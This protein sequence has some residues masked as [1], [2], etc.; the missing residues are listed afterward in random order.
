MGKVG[1][2][3]RLFSFSKELHFEIWIPKRKQLLGANGADV[4]FQWVTCELFYLGFLFPKM[5]PHVLDEGYLY[6]GLHW[7]CQCGTHTGFVGLLNWICSGFSTR[8]PHWL[9]MWGWSW[10]LPFKILIF[11]LFILLLRCKNAIFFSFFLIM[12]YIWLYFTQ[13]IILFVVWFKVKHRTGKM[14]L[15]Y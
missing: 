5:G 11:N 12:K 1:Q 4:G 13:T 15:L 2:K 6:V 8:A 3:W 10:Y 9:A 7:V 14:D